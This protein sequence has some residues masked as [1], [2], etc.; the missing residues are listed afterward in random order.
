[1]HSSMAQEDFNVVYYVRGFPKPGT[2]GRGLST[3]GHFSSTMVLDA[4]LVGAA[5][6][7]RCWVCAEACWAAVLVESILAR[8]LYYSRTCTHPS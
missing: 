3:R 6:L 7:L 8:W 1:M 2:R 4:A 5:A